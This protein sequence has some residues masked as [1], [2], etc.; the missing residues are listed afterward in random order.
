ME[1]FFCDCGKRVLGIRAWI[2]LLHAT[3]A[4]GRWPDHVAAQIRGAGVKPLRMP[5]TAEGCLAEPYA[6]STSPGLERVQS[7]GA[8]RL[9]DISLHK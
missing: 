9:L 3:E 6:L 1:V 2:A 8:T 4:G 5:P 7:G